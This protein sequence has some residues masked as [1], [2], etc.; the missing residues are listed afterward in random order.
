MLSLS[1]SFC[2]R[3]DELGWFCLVWLSFF[4]LAPSRL[5]SHPPPHSVGARKEAL[6]AVKSVFRKLGVKPSWP[7][8]IAL[9]SWRKQTLILEKEMKERKLYWGKDYLVALLF[10]GPC[11]VIDTRWSQLIGSRVE[12]ISKSGMPCYVPSESLCSVR[13]PAFLHAALL[14]VGVGVFVHFYSGLVLIP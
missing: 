13:L 2:L 3:K 4:L 5:P 6:R 8:R 7:S 12:R 9:L 10:L 14:G 11:L 1:F